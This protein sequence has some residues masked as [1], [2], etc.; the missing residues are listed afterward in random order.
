MVTLT[1]TLDL[2]EQLVLAYRQAKKSEKAALKKKIERLFALEWRQQ[3]EEAIRQRNIDALILAMDEL[4]KEAE[5]NGM[6]EEIL[7]Q[8]LAES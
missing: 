1:L 6:T 4:G 7:D 5:S 3:D 8:I 2:D